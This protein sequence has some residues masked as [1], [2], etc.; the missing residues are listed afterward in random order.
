MLL[1]LLM[2]P[3]A[4]TLSLALPKTSRPF[5]GFPTM[6]GDDHASAPDDDL[7]QG[8]VAARCLA[9]GVADDGYGR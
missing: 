6:A 7:F 3:L 1:L 4:L 5:L 9:R 2:L 8:L